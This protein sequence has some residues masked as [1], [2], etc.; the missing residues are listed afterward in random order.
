MLDTH[1]RAVNIYLFVD[2]NYTGNFVARR[3]YTGI[4]MFIQNSPIICFSKKQNTVE[5][6]TFGNELVALRIRKNLIVT[7]RYTLRMFSVRL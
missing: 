7:L 2:A 1:G 6:A 3:S 5:T 4:I